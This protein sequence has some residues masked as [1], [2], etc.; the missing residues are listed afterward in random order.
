MSLGLRLN[1]IDDPLQGGLKIECFM[2]NGEFAALDFG[3]VQHI[4]DQAEQMT[5]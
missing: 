4:V 5:G 2:C 1:E 3:H